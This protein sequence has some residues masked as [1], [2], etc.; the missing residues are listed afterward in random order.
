[1]LDSKVDHDIDCKARAVSPTPPPFQAP[2][3]EVTREWR[4]R[5]VTLWQNSPFVNISVPTF[6]HSEI[7][8][9]G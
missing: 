2:S 1:M 3:I 7:N 8:F 5:V 9:A 6:G 4:A